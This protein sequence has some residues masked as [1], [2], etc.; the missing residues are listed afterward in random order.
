MSKT[1]M[2][3]MK[4]DDY[5]NLSKVSSKNIYNVSVSN[6]KKKELN[7]RHNN[8]KITNDDYE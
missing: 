4:L 1:K 6:E 5:D 8:Y 3:T 2:I 7:H